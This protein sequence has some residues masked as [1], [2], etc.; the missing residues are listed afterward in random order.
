MEPGRSP[1]AAACRDGAADADERGLLD[2]ARAS[3]LHGVRD[4]CPLVPGANGLPEAWRAPAAVF[5]TLRETDGALRGCIG[6]L[7][8]TR[9]LA[10]D[11]AVNA[12]RAAFADPRFAP[13]GEDEAAAVHIHLAVLGP[14]ERIA[15]A[16]EAELLAALRPGVDGVALR[17]GP[18]R[19]TFLPAV[20]EQLPE[21][22]RFVAALWGKAG[23]APGHWSAEL[24]LFRYA[25][26]SIG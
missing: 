21:P 18:S 20:W 17:N 1:E 3:I 23:L 26:R 15:V 8:A 11:V 4:G 10:A 7:E 25:A 2:V 5:V 13:L 12:F 14:L 24:E 22:Q 16:C 6:S 9:P 19:A